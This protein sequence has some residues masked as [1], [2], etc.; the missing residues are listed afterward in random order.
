VATIVFGIWF[1]RHI[2]TK[3]YSL[4]GKCTIPF[5]SQHI[6]MG[7]LNQTVDSSLFIIQLDWLLDVRSYLHMGV[8][9]ESCPLEHQKK[10]AP[11][12]LWSILLE[13]N[14]HYFG[15]DMVLWHCLD[16]NEATT[17]LIELHKGVGGGHFSVNI[18]VN[19]SWMQ[20]IGGLLS[21]KIHC[22]FI[23][24]AMNVKK[25]E[26]WHSQAWPILWQPYNHIH[27]WNGVW[28]SLELWNQ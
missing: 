1:Y 18:T 17:I 27:L 24:H 2:Q 21:T 14:L 11:K 6:A 4:C 8:F 20:G 9:H 22:T 12:A 23:N 19:K 10:I 3:T 7:V 28:I 13:G 15:H 5:P 16:P 26:I 25:L